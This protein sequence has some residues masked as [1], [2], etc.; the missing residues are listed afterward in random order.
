MWLLMRGYVTQWLGMRALPSI[1]LSILNS[2]SLES[3]ASLD[4]Q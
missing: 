3:N 2:Q 4:K 1:L